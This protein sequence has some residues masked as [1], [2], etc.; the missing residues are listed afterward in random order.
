MKNLVPFL[1][2]TVVVLLSIGLLVTIQRSPA[3][4]STLGSADWRER[5]QAACMERMH[6]THGDAPEEA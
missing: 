5:M 4:R 3:V 2:T 1:F 6:M